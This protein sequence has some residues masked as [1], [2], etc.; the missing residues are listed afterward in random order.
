MMAGTKKPKTRIAT[1]CPVFG[2]PQELCGIALPTYEGIMKCYIWWK[3]KLKPTD[4]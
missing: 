3:N 2:A 1:M 4:D